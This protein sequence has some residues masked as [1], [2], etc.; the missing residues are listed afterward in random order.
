MSVEVDVTASAAHCPLEELLRI[1][2]VAGTIGP[3]L[4]LSSA[5]VDEIRAALRTDPDVE[6]FSEL[7]TTGEEVLVRI[8]WDVESNVLFDTVAAADGTVM[9]AAATD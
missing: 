7:E 4:R 1:V 6:R 5:S 2:P 8:E 3:Y 9:K